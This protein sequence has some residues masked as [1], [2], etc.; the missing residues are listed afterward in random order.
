MHRA[1]PAFF[2]L[3]LMALA[4]CGV[5]PTPTAPSPVATPTPQEIT[6]DEAIT[7]AL[8]ASGVSMPGRS[9]VADPRNPIARLTT[10]GAYWS[11]LGR[12]PAEIGEDQQVWIVQLEGEIVLEGPPPVSARREYSFALYS[13]DA[14]TGAGAGSTLRN[15]PVLAAE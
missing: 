9:S 8:N 14:R 5:D 1:V 11:L 6:E 12:P 3:I 13:F 15:T 7:L 2:M 10:L 4:A